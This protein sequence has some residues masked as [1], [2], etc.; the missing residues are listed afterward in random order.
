MLE[1]DF[2]IPQTFERFGKNGMEKIKTFIWKPEWKPYKGYYFVHWVCK[3]SL[4]LILLLSK[5][6]PDQFCIA[7]RKCYMGNILS[8]FSYHIFK[9]KVDHV[10]YKQNRSILFIKMQFWMNLCTRKDLFEIKNLIVFLLLFNFCLFFSIS[11]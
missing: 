11:S 3:V 9:E 4:T 5:S 7:S 10:Y 6:K 1:Q 2:S 8:N